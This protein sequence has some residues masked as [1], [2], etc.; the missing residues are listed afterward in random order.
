[1]RRSGESADVLVVGAG[2]AG[3]LAGLAVSREGL[4]VIVAERSYTPGGLT[5]TSLVSEMLGYTFLGQSIYGGIESEIVEKLLDAGAAKLYYDTPMVPSPYVRVDRFC[6]NPEALKILLDWFIAGSTIRAVGGCFVQSAT[7]LDDGFH[8]VIGDGIDEF[9]IVS[10]IVIDATG[11]AGVCLKA[12][13]ETYR[14]QVEREG[15]SLLFRLSNTDHDSIEAFM[16]GDEIYEVIQRGYEEGIF[17]G[18]YLSVVL[19]PGTHDVIVD[20]TR[21]FVDPASPMDITKGVINARAQLLKILPYLKDNVPGLGFAGLASVAPELTIRDG[22]RITGLSR[23]TQEDILSLR[24]FP[25]G[26][27]WGCAPMGMHDAIDEYVDWKEIGG[28]YQI[29]YSAMI[30]KGSRRV[31]AAGKCISC[32]NMAATTIRRIPVMMNTGE[33]AG[34]SAAMA[35]KQNVPPAGLDTGLLKRYLAGKGIGPMAPPNRPIP[36][37]PNVVPRSGRAYV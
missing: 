4:D 30:P 17:S 28:I 18:K 27:A 21:T 2:I 11:D 6:Y 26:V 9:E 14:S 3:V 22:R 36:T 37:T 10:D 20:A 1:M 31:I 24:D 25:D 8:T 33:V 16:K 35:I 32:D 29:P 12:G 13:F 23:V 34:F 19:I 15:A 5:T 7:E